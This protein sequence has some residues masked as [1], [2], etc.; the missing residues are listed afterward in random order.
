MG[1]RFHDLLRNVEYGSSKKERRAYARA[2]LDKFEKENKRHEN[3]M[4]FVILAIYALAIWMSGHDDLTLQ[5][6]LVLITGTLF[7]SWS[8]GRS[9][10]IGQSEEYRL[11]HE[12]Q[13]LEREEAENTTETQG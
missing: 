12:V 7:A 8:M 11:R 10:V 1:L 6:T 2:E 3:I 4:F 9:G 13:L 5:V